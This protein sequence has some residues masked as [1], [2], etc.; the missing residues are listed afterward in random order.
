[1]VVVNTLFKYKRIYILLLI[2]I[3]F[4]LLM[5]SKYNAFFAEE[6]MARRIYFISAQGIS[7]I[8]GMLPF[9]IIEVILILLPIIILGIIILFLKKLFIT[10][11]KKTI[12][13]KAIL[14]ILSF[15]S[16]LLFL[17]IILCGT[18]Y[19]R[20]TFSQYS[21]LEIKDSSL[22]ELYELSLHLVEDVN[23]FRENVMENE[24]GVFVLSNDIYKTAKI[25]SESYKLASKQYPVLGGRYPSS[26]PV[27][28]SK[29]MSKAE[30]TGIFIP[31][32]M[33]A[34]INVDVPDYSIPAT[35]NHELAHLRGF[36]REDEANFIAYITCMASDSFDLKYS[37]S[38]LAL[39]TANNALYNQDKDLY[40][41]IRD[42]MSEKVIRD[43]RDNNEYWQQYEDTVISVVSNKVNDAF[44]KANN[45]TDGVKS[46]GRML[47]LLL[48]YHKIN[49]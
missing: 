35:M 45:Q 18:N 7:M 13:I 12:I 17:Y 6:I 34:N 27:L 5:L 37:G 15:F 11:D 23:K 20:Y 28:L 4:A 44:L 40:F 43:I 39:I 16:I 47:D 41:D 9:S 49:Q 14:N 1:M 42:T 46:Y 2:P 19:Y 48:A 32:T 30:T 10:K 22:E 21:N 38:M 8:T 25:S 24:D 31:F 3:S 33:E 29:L 26:K 36:M